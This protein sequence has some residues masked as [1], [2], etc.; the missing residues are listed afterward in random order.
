VS[1]HAPA[2]SP[3]KADEQRKLVAGNERRRQDDDRAHREPTRDLRAQPETAVRLELHRQHS[4]AI[5]EPVGES[6]AER[7]ERARH[8]EESQARTHAVSAEEEDQAAGADAEERHG[9]DQ[10]EGV[11]GAAEERGEH[12]VP[13]DLHQEEG[14]AQHAGGGVDEGALGSRRLFGAGL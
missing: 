9:E 7:F 4:D 5:A 10:S 2:A 13:D 3:E 14:E 6:H 1:R 11:G 12:A 8:G